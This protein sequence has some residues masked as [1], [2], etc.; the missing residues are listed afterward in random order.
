[1]AKKITQGYLFASDD[2]KISK[3]ATIVVPMKIDKVSN[4]LLWKEVSQIVY[5]L[6]ITAASLNTVGAI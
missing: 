3:G 6:A 2:Q 1:E 4:I 5:Q